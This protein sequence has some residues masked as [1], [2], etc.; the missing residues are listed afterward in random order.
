MYHKLVPRGGPGL[1]CDEAGIALGPVE[2]VTTVNSG[3]STPLY[4]SISPD[5]VEDV[6]TAAY[7]NQNTLYQ[8]WFHS[9]LNAIA[10]AM[11]AGRHVFA[12]IAA[13][14]LALPEISAHNLGL[15][16][17]IS[18]LTKFNPRWLQEPRDRHGRW[19][20]EGNGRVIPVIEPYSPECLAAI[21]AAK[22]ICFAQYALRGGQLGFAWMRRC[23]RGYVPSGCGY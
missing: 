2:L 22:K 20:E 1:S 11:S 5:N 10:E 3:E 4:R 13:V 12:R 7:G 8:E 17:K 16:E 9:R 18:H 23:I 14:Q 15:L 19:T 21:E 6:L